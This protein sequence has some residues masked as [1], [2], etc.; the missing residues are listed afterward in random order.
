MEEH[1]TSRQTLWS[2]ERKKEDRH[3]WLTLPILATWEDPGLRPALANSLRDP[4]LQNNQSK[5]D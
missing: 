5:M 2:K 4:H 1:L 3:W